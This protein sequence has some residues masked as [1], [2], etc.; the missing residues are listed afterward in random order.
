MFD[1]QLPMYKF[2]LFP[3]LF[4]MIMII[5]QPARVVALVFLYHLPKDKESFVKVFS[6]VKVTMS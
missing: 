1:A 5:D 3:K 2:F 6:L 4:S